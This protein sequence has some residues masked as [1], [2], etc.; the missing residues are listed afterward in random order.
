MGKVIVKVQLTSQSD[1]VLKSRKVLKGNPREVEA[2]TLVD[3][4][5][6]RLYLKPSVIRALGL[7]KV[8]RVLSQTTN[9]IRRRG[10]YEPVRLEILGRRGI[11]EVVDIDEHLPNLLGQIPLEYLDLVVA[12]KR[13]RLIPNPEHGE[14]LMTEEY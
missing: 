8:D 3:T 9:G 2:E 4:G 7:K 1:L 14:K 10:V 13:R 6:T 12:T 5:A 11:F